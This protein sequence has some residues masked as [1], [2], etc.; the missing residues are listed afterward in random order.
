MHAYISIYVCIHAWLTQA[1]LQLEHTFITVYISSQ[2]IVIFV[3]TTLIGIVF[4]QLDND[5][6]GYQNRYTISL[7]PTVQSLLAIL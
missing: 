4:F 2:V 6:A 5:F 3:L 7:H 1:V